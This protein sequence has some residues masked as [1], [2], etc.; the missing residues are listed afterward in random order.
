MKIKMI[1]CALSILLL[2]TALTPAARAE[3]ID[4]RL[5]AYAIENAA[6]GESYTVMVSVGAVLINRLTSESYPS[7]LAAVITDAGIDIS[8]NEPSSRALRAA[9]DAVGGFDPTGGALHYQNSEYDCK[10]ALAADSWFFY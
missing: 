9:A 5:L 2:V 8:E 3:E 10:I 4:V 1:C 6:R 7:S